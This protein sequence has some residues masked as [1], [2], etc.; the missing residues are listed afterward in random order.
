[1]LWFKLI[2]VQ[3]PENITSKR[4]C[5]SCVLVKKTPHSESPDI[6][7]PVLEQIVLV[8]L[9][10]RLLW[11]YCRIKLIKKIPPLCKSLCCISSVHFI[12]SA[13]INLTLNLLQ[14]CRVSRVQSYVQENNQNDTMLCFYLFILFSPP[15]FFCFVLFSFLP[16][17]C[18]YCEHSQ[19]RW[20][21]YHDI[22]V[23]LL[24]CFCWSRAGINQP[25][26]Q[27]AV[28]L[29]GCFTFPLVY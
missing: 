6:Y 29:I 20:E 19:T 11:Q 25:S 17:F 13:P 9:R 3:L 21:S 26:L 23:L 10:S 22:C 8:K 15:R 12:L 16:P 1:M 4:I 7:M 2:H 14:L 24:P 18:R 5:L 27:V 28:V